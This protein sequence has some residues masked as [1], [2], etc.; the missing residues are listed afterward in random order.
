ME[1]VKPKVESQRYGPLSVSLSGEILVADP[2]A[3]TVN[4]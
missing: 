1:E 3:L 4:A 2:L